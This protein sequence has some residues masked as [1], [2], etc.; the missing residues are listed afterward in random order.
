[1][2]L[3]FLPWCTSSA[4]SGI[5]RFDHSAGARRVCQRTGPECGDSSLHGRVNVGV[6]E[7]GQRA[8]FLEGGQEAGI[9]SGYGEHTVVGMQGVNETG[10]CE[11]GGVVDI[12]Q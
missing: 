4:S 9:C 8:V 10:E 6:I 5:C 2:L 11:A 12:V 1:M 3:I 7:T